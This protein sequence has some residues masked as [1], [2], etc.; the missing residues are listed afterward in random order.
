[1]TS[2]WR[3]SFSQNPQKETSLHLTFD[4]WELANNPEDPV[5]LRL[6]GWLERFSEIALHH[7]YGVFSPVDADLMLPAGVHALPIHLPLG[8]LARARWEQGLLPRAAARAGADLLCFGRRTSPI[9]SRVATTCIQEM[10]QSKRGQG[11]PA[12]LALALGFA[13]AQMA[14]SILRADDL[15]IGGQRRGGLRLYPPYVNP[16]FSPIAGDADQEIYRRFGLTH[17]FVLA[18][19]PAPS[20]LRALL[21]GWSWAAPSVG[22]LSPLLILGLHPGAQELAHHIVAEYELQG[23]VRLISGVASDGLPAIYRGAQVLLHPGVS[24]TGME[25]RWA[26]A[27]GTPVAAYESPSIDQ[28]MGPAVYLVPAGDA[29]ALGAACLALLLDANV[30]KKL[31]ETGLERAAIYQQADRPRRILDL[32]IQIARGVGGG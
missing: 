6:L 25:L 23:T 15:P 12:R 16:A 32:L 18:H 30:S 7:R 19:S 29:R 20:T 22:D 2:A 28:L 9:L 4:G 5:A 8:R 10:D 13:G 21:A 31:R 26:M 24:Q 14:S 11:F 17:G 1:M 27:S 3:I